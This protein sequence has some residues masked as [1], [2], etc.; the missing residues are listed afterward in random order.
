MDLYHTA[1]HFPIDAGAGR[2]R[3]MSN[4]FTSFSLKV[5][6]FFAPIWGGANGAAL[7]LHHT[8]NQ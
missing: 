2:V 7:T 8:G 3:R 6:S 4:D 5:G 1:P